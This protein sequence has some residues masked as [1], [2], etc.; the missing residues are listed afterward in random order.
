[1]IRFDVTIVGSGLAGLPVVR[2]LGDDRLRIK[3]DG[4]DLVSACPNHMNS[5]LSYLDP[6]AVAK[7]E[8]YAESVRACMT[9]LVSSIRTGTP[10]NS[11]AATAA[12][13]VQVAAAATAA[14]GL[15]RTVPLSNREASQPILAVGG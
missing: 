14:A 7:A 10:T 12:A 8:V 1:M 4:M 6:T 5:P 9:D 13:A 2:G 11:N 3:V 15:G